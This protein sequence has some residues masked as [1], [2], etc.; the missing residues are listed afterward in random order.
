M[1]GLN[2]ALMLEQ[3]EYIGALTRTAGA[4]LTIHD[5]NVFPFPEDNGIDLSPGKVTSVGLTAVSAIQLK[6]PSFKLEFVF[7]FRNYL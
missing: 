6:L 3:D 1:T 2:L 4:R 7:L 5:K